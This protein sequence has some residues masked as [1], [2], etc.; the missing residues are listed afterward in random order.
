ML[1][2]KNTQ[3]LKLVW[4]SIKVGN[5]P[6]NQSSLGLDNHLIWKQMGCSYEVM[7]AFKNSIEE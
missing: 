3:D 2:G 1:K 7:N 6:W 5:S 4:R